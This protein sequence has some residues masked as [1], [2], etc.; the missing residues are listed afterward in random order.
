M[1]FDGITTAALVREFD[2]ALRGGHISRISQTE[3]DELY[4]TVKNNRKNLRLVLSVNASLPLAYL[5]DDS[6]AAPISAPSFCM[7]LRKHMN[8]GKI[9]SVT[10]PGLERAIH[11]RV[12][13]RNEMGDLGE[14]ELICELMGKYSNIIFTGADGVII[15]SIKRISAQVSS[16]RE[17]LPGR[18]YFLPQ[19]VKKT[20]ILN[21]STEEIAALLMT[22][23]VPAGK[24]CAAVFTGISNAA[25][26]NF[27]AAAGIDAD[28]PA[29]ALT[30]A[31]RLHLAGTVSLAME[32]VR[33][34]R[35]TPVILYRGGDPVEFSALMPVSLPADE[36]VRHFA[37]M[38][39]VV[40]SYYG[41]RDLISRIRQKSQ[42]LRHVVSTILERDY[43]KLDIQEKQLRD[44][45]KKDRYRLY[46]ELLNTYGYELKGGEKQL[47]CEN[48]YTN[49][50]V[51]IPLDPTLTARENAQKFF[52]RYDKL[53]RTEEATS[54]LL[55]ETRAEIDHLESISAS[56]DI[57][58]R[59]EDLA[60]I[61][62]EMIEYGFLHRKGPQARKAK[63]T[64]RP[65]HYRSTDGF[66]LYVGKNNYQNEELTFRFAS[67][68]DWWFHA[69][70][71]PGSHVILKNDGRPIPDRAFEEAGALAA[72][73]SKGR[74]AD[75]VEIDYIQRK[76]LRKV[77]GGAPGFVIYHTNY[78][79]MAKP[80]LTLEEVKDR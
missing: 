37:S 66:D 8:G 31:E 57:A 53:K 56:L 50:E 41:A 71:M 62:Q 35:F 80:E 12:E 18:K 40:E 3:K 77:N 70:K 43:K 32:D 1:A 58:L 68:N 17:V 28:T 73:Y 78:S 65:F 26:Q 47:V 16:V 29:S 48:Y 33:E 39:Q 52:A 60:E 34:G 36:T 67:G 61:R 5:S 72:Y 42:D 74:N 24:V 20:D 22:S 7:L 59:E 63:I 2:S 51:T 54:H 19:T 46:G 45:E 15:D 27:C 69:K 14:A 75:K 38:S 23:Q 49:Q 55:K 25:A 9:L 30:D 6:K 10:Q 76:Q 4:I 44:T 21:A 64:S 11:V 13:H 79:L